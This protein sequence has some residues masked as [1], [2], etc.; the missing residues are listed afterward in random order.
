[1]AL[2]SSAPVVISSSAG[3]II[4]LSATSDPRFSTGLEST[5]A[6]FG[7]GCGNLQ[8]SRKM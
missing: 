7:L 4:E 5:T 6:R 2:V 3:V 8:H 1:M